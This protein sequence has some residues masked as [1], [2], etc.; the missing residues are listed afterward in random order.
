MDTRRKLPGCNLLPRTGLRIR[1]PSGLPL[2]LPLRIP[3]RALPGWNTPSQLPS[4]GPKIV[5]TKVAVETP[6]SEEPGFGSTTV[7]PAATCSPP[8]LRPRIRLQVEEADRRRIDRGM[9]EDR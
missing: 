8:C 9:G 5:P 7:S 4:L 1:N 6:A 2:V 3:D